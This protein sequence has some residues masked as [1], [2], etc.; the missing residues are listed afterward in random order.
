MLNQLFSRILNDSIPPL[1]ESDCQC[2]SADHSSPSGA[3]LCTE[4][5]VFNLLNA[6]DTNK[7]SGPDGISEKM[8]KATT[9]SITPVL[10]ELFDL[11]ITSGS[12]PQKWKLSSV[13]LIPKSSNIADNPLK[14]RP[15]S[16][17]SETLG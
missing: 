8:V 15:I 6:L 4:E 17:W 10:M 1:S 2:F 11:S 5:E 13:V 9:G 14:Y 7:A 3:I 16:Q 12:I